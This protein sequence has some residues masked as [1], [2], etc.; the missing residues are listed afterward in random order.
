MEEKETAKTVHAS[1]AT[2]TDSNMTVLKTFLLM[3][4]S[5]FKPAKE[6]R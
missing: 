5:I 4:F 1:I 2:M 6:I 3:L